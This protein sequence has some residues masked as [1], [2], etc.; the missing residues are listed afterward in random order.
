MKVSCELPVLGII[1]L[2]TTKRKKHPTFVKWA[3]ASWTGFL[4]QSKSMGR[5]KKKEVLLL[6]NSEAI[7]VG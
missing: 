7:G 3:P 6:L 4:K 2:Y 1:V 5:D